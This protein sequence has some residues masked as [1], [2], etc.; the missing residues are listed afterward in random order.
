MP[1][2]PRSLTDYFPASSLRWSQETLNDTP[3]TTFLK[4]VTQICDAINHCVRNFPRKKNNAFTT[5]S[6]AS[7]QRL[8]MSSFALLLS[9]FEIFQKSQFAEI[10]NAIDFMRAFDDIKLVNDL[11]KEGCTL[12]LQRILAGRGDPREPGQ[13]IADAMPGW[14]DP[15]KV[16]AY[17]KI[18]FP[19]DIY[20]KNII[21]ELQLMWQLRHSIVHTGGVISQ[22]DAIKAPLLRGL[23]ERK[24]EFTDDFIVASGRRLHIIVRL[25][26][27]QL[28]NA[29]RKAIDPT[30]EE[31]ESLIESIVGCDSPR[32]SWLKVQ[33]E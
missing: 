15:G 20:S 4:E 8:S 5:A 30:L 18:L 3:A 17:F 31:P 21:S 13:I 32:R 1:L 25:A 19:V 24:L 6:A 2:F 26:T 23:G 33:H 22:E 28:E 10:I 27:T 12:S 14:H 9:H 11:K 7:F 16:N 29:V